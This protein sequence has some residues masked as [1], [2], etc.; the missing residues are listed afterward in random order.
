MVQKMEYKFVGDNHKA[1]LPSTDV[2]M[3]RGI[4]N[5]SMRRATIK[6][7]NFIQNLAGQKGMTLPGLPQSVAE[8]ADW[9][10]YLK[11]LSTPRQ[12]QYVKDL[13]RQIDPDFNV[14]VETWDEAQEWINGLRTILENPERTE[15]FRE[16]LRELA[17][18][19]DKSETNKL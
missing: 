3:A 4:V 8:A 5:E 2:A 19:V 13:C 15:A 16:H 18:K 12:R 10:A 7:W 14:D 1:T 17:D 9:I 6:Q 11:S